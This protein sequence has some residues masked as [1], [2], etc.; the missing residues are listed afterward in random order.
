[1]GTAQPVETAQQASDL[2]AVRAI[3]EA[4][5]ASSRRGTGDEL[6]LRLLTGACTAVGVTP[7]A[8]DRRILEW[9][10][11][12][13]PETYAVIAGLITRAAEGRK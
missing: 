7:G 2:P 1:M 4:M 8:Y 10:A 9:L 12:W 11:E 5:H 6:N 13:E 3:Y